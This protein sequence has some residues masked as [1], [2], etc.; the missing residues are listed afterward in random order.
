MLI[1]GAVVAEHQIAEQS[2]ADLR[3]AEALAFPLLFVLSLLFFRGLIASAL[4]LV[5]GGAAI[6]GALFAMRLIH[7]VFGLSVLAIN[8]VTAIGFGLAID[9]S[10]FVVSRFREGLAKRTRKEA[11]L[12]ITIRTL[13]PR[14]RLQRPDGGLRDGV[15]P[16][17]PATLPAVHGGRRLRGGDCVA[18]LAGLVV[19]PALLGLLGDKRQRLLAR[20][21]AALPP[22]Q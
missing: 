18:A 13:G 22:G 1:G 7:E 8:V 16:L 6:V 11:A 10:L 4:P 9:Y 14:D 19:L 12:A 21:A 15:A 2:E 5:I 20:V 3:V 17:L